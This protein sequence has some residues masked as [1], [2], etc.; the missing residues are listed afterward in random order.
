[1]SEIEI[2]L[3]ERAEAAIE[4]IV[5]DLNNGDWPVRASAKAATVAVLRE[6]SEEV[7]QA[8]DE[9]DGNMWPDS[10]DLS[11]IADALEEA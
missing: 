6:L 7:A 8:E 10:G 9:D 3:W 2:R 11:L 5:M 4:K 1:M